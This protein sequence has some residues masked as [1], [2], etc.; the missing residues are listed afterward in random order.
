M[1][2]FLPGFFFN[3]LEFD[4]IKIGIMRMFPESNKADR[5]AISHPVMI[6]QSIIERLSFTNQFHSG[7]DKAVLH[8]TDGSNRKN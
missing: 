1:E 4:V 5:I 7:I 6:I 8:S 3:C 2:N